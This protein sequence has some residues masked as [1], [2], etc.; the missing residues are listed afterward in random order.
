VRHAPALLALAL[1]G[2]GGAEQPQPPPQPSP[3]IAAPSPTPGPPIDDRPQPRPRPGEVA[4]ALLPAPE[5]EGALAPGTW[6]L[7]A[8]ATG[9]AALFGEANSE[10]RFAIRCEPQGRRIV[11]VRSVPDGAR[12]RLVTE[13]G[14]ASFAARPRTD[15]MPSLEAESPAQFTFLT[16]VIARATGRIA[17]QVDD[18]APLVLPADRVIG[19]VIGSC[20]PG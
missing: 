1:T 11:L 4:G 5:L 6:T 15:G 2:C 17:V 8:S 13:R 3:T 18:A 19:Q 16:Q 7:K 12:I 20:Q 10:P 9:A 14:A